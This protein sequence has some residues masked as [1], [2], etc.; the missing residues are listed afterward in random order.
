M[1]LAGAAVAGLVLA[2][3]VTASS[4]AAEA[5]DLQCE[6][7]GAN[8]DNLITICSKELFNEQWAQ[9]SSAIYIGKKS[10]TATGCKITTWVELG[11]W[12]NEDPG[13]WDPQS[14]WNSP[15]ASNDC[16]FRLRKGQ[17]VQDV[18]GARTTTS[19]DAARGHSC[20]DLYYGGSSHSGM[21]LC[22]QTEWIG[23]H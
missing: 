21:Q 16:S 2:S 7:V 5:S 9:T 3:T 4:A 18:A 20:M 14:R 12:G 10:T 6:S 8:A 23:R 17:T 15:K 11:N 22:A 1:H 19:A 13:P